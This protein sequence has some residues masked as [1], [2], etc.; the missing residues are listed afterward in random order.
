MALKNSRKVPSTAS[1][2]KSSMYTTLASSTSSPAVNHLTTKPTPSK[3][4]L[5]KRSREPPSSLKLKLVRA[6]YAHASPSQSHG[7]PAR[8]KG[9]LLPSSIDCASAI[10]V[11]AVSFWVTSTSPASTLEFKTMAPPRF[12]CP[13]CGV[14]DSRGRRRCDHC[15]CA[16]CFMALPGAMPCAAAGSKRRCDDASRR[17]DVRATTKAPLAPNTPLRPPREKRAAAAVCDT[18][19]APVRRRADD[20]TPAPPET[21]AR[22]RRRRVALPARPKVARRSRRLAAAAKVAAAPMASKASEAVGT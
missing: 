11:R 9:P 22:P 21:P 7:C 2:P 14:V 16:R 1:G 15:R 20:A 18:L 10:A 17:D 6:R 3:E 8:L 12:T 13:L 4:A 5:R 19:E